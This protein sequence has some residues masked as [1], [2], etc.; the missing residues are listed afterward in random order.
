LHQLPRHDPQVETLL[1]QA[2]DTLAYTQVLGRMGHEEHTIALTSL[3]PDEAPAYFL[4][5]IDSALLRPF[6]AS[7][8]PLDI[9]EALLKHFGFFAR[10]L[11]EDSSQDGLYY[12]GINPRNIMLVGNQQA[13]IDFEQDSLRSRFIDIVS[14][15]ENGLEMTEWDDSADYPA[16]S[17]QMAFGTWERQRQ[18]AQ[19]ALSQ[20]NY[21]P[22]PRIERLTAAFIDTTWQLEQQHLQGRRAPY[23]P[24]EYRLI[25]ETARLFRHLQ[26]VGY[27]KRNSREGEGGSR[28]FAGLGGRRR[29]NPV[30]AIRHFRLACLGGPGAASLHR[31]VHPGAVF[32][33]RLPPNRRQH[34]SDLP[35]PRFG[36]S[37]HRFPHQPEAE[38]GNLSR[39]DPSHRDGR[40]LG[41]RLVGGRL[42]IG[43]KRR[44]QL[45]PDQGT[46]IH[47]R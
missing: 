27:C 6:A 33:D 28:V 9:G 34:A 39:L 24:A 21:L 18:H 40:F 46:P 7:G 36:Q 43:R 29:R 25:L 44:T 35:V 19:G 4:E 13:E 15:L 2:S 5:Q 8:K 23:P 38:P 37:A 1:E 14:L 11:G 30:F 26:Y 12:R 10:V 16:Y 31:P 17:G 20:Y 3:T 41:W 32:P 42:Q 45:F 47:R 22:H